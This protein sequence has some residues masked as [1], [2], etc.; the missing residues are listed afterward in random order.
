M[1]IKDEGKHFHLYAS[2]VLHKTKFTYVVIALMLILPR[3]R[4]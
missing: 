4:T 1:Q 3:D 2:G